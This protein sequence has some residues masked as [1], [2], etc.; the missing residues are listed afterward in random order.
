MRAFCIAI[1]ATS[2]LA[3]S[4]ANAADIANAQ[5]AKE[6]TGALICLRD[7]AGGGLVSQETAA[8][9]P[10]WDVQPNSWEPY[11]RLAIWRD[12]ATL[13]ATGVVPE[14]GRDR[15][16]KA[17]PPSELFKKAVA[18]SIVRISV[19]NRNGQISDG[20]MTKVVA[21]LSKHSEDPF[22]SAAIG[23]CAGNA[24]LGKDAPPGAPKPTNGYVSFDLALQWLQSGA[25]REDG[26]IPVDPAKVAVLLGPPEASSKVP[27]FAYTSS[28]KPGIAASASWYRD[29]SGSYLSHV[30]DKP[31][32]A[33]TLRLSLLPISFV[34]NDEQV[35]RV[36]SGK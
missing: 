33:T 10:T 11:Y 12:L 21:I 29:P 2:A 3:I 8:L 5:D 4:A 1:L 17:D 36:K 19:Y 30:V 16:A 27:A 25:I 34:W 23:T 15:I 31:R 26:W 32:R 13:A 14:H 22:A 20:V 24:Y 9:I 28:G 35:A 6:L 7:S 18:D